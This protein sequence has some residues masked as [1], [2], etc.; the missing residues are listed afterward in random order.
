[1]NLFT[2][3]LEGWELRV[4]STL[5]EI[6]PDEPAADLLIIDDD[7]PPIIGT[8]PPLWNEGL[9]IRLPNLPIILLRSTTR[10]PE[11]DSLFL[12]LP[13]PFPVALFKAFIAAVQANKHKPL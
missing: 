12:A 1:L 9:G 10:A 13:K 5:E 6:T 2:L 7:P 4:I 8:R 11:E 3:L